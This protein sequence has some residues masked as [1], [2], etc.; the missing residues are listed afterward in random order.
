MLPDFPEVFQICQRQR[1]NQRLCAYRSGRC[2][3]QKVQSE[4]SRPYQHG[5]I[6]FD[7]G[8]SEERIV[9]SQDYIELH[10]GKPHEGSRAF[11]DGNGVPHSSIMRTVSFEATTV[12]ATSSA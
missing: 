1:R 11:S 4:Q 2:R 5:S 12:N 10:D 8:G 9:R 3:T 6:D 7:L